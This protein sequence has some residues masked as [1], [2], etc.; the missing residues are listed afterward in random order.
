M[1]RDY[2]KAAGVFSEEVRSDFKELAE[3]HWDK[4]MA[5]LREIMAQRAPV[6]PPD[7]STKDIVMANKAITFIDGAKKAKIEQLL[8]LARFRVGGDVKKTPD[9]MRMDIIKEAQAAMS[10]KPVAKEID[11]DTD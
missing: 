3:D 7:A 10:K 11:G 1:P 4:E 9:E 8:R 5:E 6:P 2:L